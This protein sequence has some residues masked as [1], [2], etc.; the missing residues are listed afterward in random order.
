[1][2]RERTEMYRVA[3]K[4]GEGNVQMEYVEINSKIPMMVKANK[5]RMKNS[6][7]QC[8]ETGQTSNLAQ[9]FT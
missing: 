2:A 5:L 7:T 1:M 9:L 3:L 8:I 6:L 4:S